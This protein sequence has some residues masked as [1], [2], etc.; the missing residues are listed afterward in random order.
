MGTPFFNNLGITDIQQGRS[1]TAETFPLSFNPNNKSVWEQAVH[2]LV[3][4]EPAVDW[5]TTIQRYILLCE[6]QG[7]YPF[8]S[9]QQ[10]RNDQIVDYLRERRRAFVKFIDF[11][12]F[13]DSVKLRTTERKVIVTNT[14]FVLTVTATANITD[15]SFEKWLA[16]MPFP[17]FDLVKKEGRHWKTLQTG[18]RMFAYRDHG[19]NSS[20]RWVIGYEINCP[21][22]PDLP[23]N[24]VPSKQQ[25]EKFVLDIL[26]LPI[27]RSTRP[28]KTTHRLI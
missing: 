7:V 27:L 2:E 13:F 8:Q 12:N 17:R 19:S 20:E 1:P 22:Y 5:V 25:L 15:P 24:H 3:P 6:S 18:L 9:V 21:I 16:E 10:S 26:W 14:G 11:T 23:D 4:Q 28:R